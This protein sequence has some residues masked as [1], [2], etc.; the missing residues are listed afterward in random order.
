MKE[1]FSD[2][3]KIG[4]DEILAKSNYSLGKSLLPLIC[5]FQIINILCLIIKVEIN[6]DFS[7]F[8][9]YLAL[10]LLLLVITFFLFVYLLYIPIETSSNNTLINKLTISYVIVISLWSNLINIIDFNNNNILIYVVTILTIGFLVALSPNVIIKILATN[11][12]L[13]ITFLIIFENSIINNFDNLMTSTI[14]VFIAMIS[15]YLQYNKKVTEFINKKTIM[16]Q[17]KALSEINLKDSLTNLYNRRY[18]DTTLG[19][20][21]N[22]CS[23]DKCPL[24]IVMVDLDNFKEYNDTYGHQAGDACL[25]QV[26]KILDKNSITNSGTAFRYGGEEFILLFPKM[27]SGETLGV[28]ENIRRTVE[29]LKVP[30]ENFY[31]NITISIGIYNIIPNLDT[32]IDSC[33]KEADIQLYNSKNLGKNRASI[34]IS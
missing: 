28:C 2:D 17:N 6:G 12:I 23:I 3:L 22:I 10:Y 13:F 24:S 34:N 31:L 21:I 18:L 5:L 33:I 1:H 9:I 25:V 11:H 8:S 14:V 32:S 20:Y 4:L 19:D 29:N 7:D 26:S 15:S 16:D 27:T 30:V